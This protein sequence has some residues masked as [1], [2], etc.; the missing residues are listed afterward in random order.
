MQVR[1]NL[2]DRFDEERLTGMATQLT[3]KERHHMLGLFRSVAE[4]D[5][6]MAAEHTLSFAGPNQSCP[7]PEAFRQD[8]LDHFA[9]VKNPGW[10]EEQFETSVDAFGR[11]IDIIRQHRVT[12]PGQICS[13]LFTVFLLEGWS[14]KLDPEHSIM[15]QIKSLL[16]KLDWSLERHIKD[17]AQKVLIDGIS[18]L[19][20]QVS[21]D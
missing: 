12:L 14:S 16:R 19:S 9:V 2:H 7:D 20:L 18:N 17:G 8:M 21:A 13:C 11:V 10:S 5:G 6:E 3:E 1:I 15:D 4:M